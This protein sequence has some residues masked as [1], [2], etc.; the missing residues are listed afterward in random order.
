METREAIQYRIDNIAYFI[1]SNGLPCNENARKLL[2]FNKISPH[3]S[4]TVGEVKETKKG[5]SRH[6]FSF[7]IRGENPESMSNIEANIFETLKVL[8]D[9]L[10]KLNQKEVSI[11]KIRPWKT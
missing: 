2:E 10:L 6:H 7:C 3:Q 1:T 4:K 5:N 8:R 9:L 11:A